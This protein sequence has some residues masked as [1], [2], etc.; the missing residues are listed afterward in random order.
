M[1]VHTGETGSSG[2]AL[3]VDTENLREADHAQDAIAQAVADWPGPLPLSS[4]SLYVRADKVAVWEMWAEEA[5]PDLQVRVRG[6]QHFSN[7]KAK[8]SADLAITADAIADLV[9]GQAAAVA[10]VSNDSDFGALFVKVR[11]LAQASGLQQTPFLWVTSPDAGALSPE[12]ERFIPAG[13]RWDLSGDAPE[14]APAESERTVSK[15]AAASATVSRKAAAVAAKPDGNPGNEAIADELIRRLPVGKFKVNEALDAFQARWPKHPAAAGPAQFGTFLLKEIWPMLQK[16]GVLMTRKSSP[17][18][19]EITQA[20]KESIANGS[21]GKAPNAK[22]PAQVK[23]RGKTAA[24]PAPVQLAA[25]VAV[26]ITD[27]LFSASDALNAVKAA[28]PTHSAAGMTPQRFGLW[29]SEQLWP[30]ME[31]Q[32]VVLAKEKPRRY[33]MTPD[34]RHRLTTLAED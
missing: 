32:G 12:M 2:A 17:R 16:R 28:W 15:P 22:P 21:G 9:T 14:P 29:F 24:E 25:A 13:L 30:V 8:N 5:Y 3:Y 23:G 1:G 7:H 10:V 27:D 20:A 34:A 19:Y 11:E 6:V 33:E 4:L 18:T 31:Q 26:A